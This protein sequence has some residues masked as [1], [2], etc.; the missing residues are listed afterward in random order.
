M[1]NDVWN[2]LYASYL[3]LI[4]DADYPDEDTWEE[5]R[6]KCSIC[7]QPIAIQQSGWAEGHN[8]EPIN[9]GRC[10]DTCNAT[11]VIPSRAFK[12]RSTIENG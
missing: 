3:K 2:S 5:E 4:D 1:N 7:N 8:A 10:C 6:M 12:L 11:V 9:D